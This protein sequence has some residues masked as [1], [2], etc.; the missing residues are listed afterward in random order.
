MLNA[1]RWRKLLR[2]LMRERERLILMLAA[3]T[4]SLAAVGGVMGAFGILEREIS[5]NYLGTLPADITIELSDDV[6]ERALS[7]VRQHAGV[8]DAEARDVLEARVLIGAQWQPILLFVADEPLAVRHNRA[9]LV[10]GAPSG[11]QG[12]LLERTA[13]D[14]LQVRPGQPLAIKTAH[15]PLTT[16]TVSG[17]VH[18]PSLAPAWQER[19]G[20]G[21]LSR[22]ALAALGEPPKLH[23]LRIV[24]A[25]RAETLT[26]LERLA[27]DVAHDL[28]AAGYAV[29][30]IS[31]PPPRQH[32][33]QRQ[34]TTV[35][36]LLMAFSLL[37]LV[38]SG[39][40]VANSLAAI[41]ARQVREIGVMKVLGA[42][43]SQLAAMYAVLILLVA[44]TA[45][46]VAIPLGRG[47]ALTLSTAVAML[48]NF[49]LADT[50]PPSWVVLVQLA[51]GIGV[52]LLLS[53]FPV[54]SA[55]RMSVRDAIGQ[56][57]AASDVLRQRAMRWPRPLRDLLRRPRRLVLTAG[58][59]ATAGAVF[60]TALNLKAS[61]EMNVEKV[62]QTHFYDVDVRFHAPQ[63][64]AEVRK[65]LAAIPSVRR[66]EA[67][68]YAPAAFN[69]G[70]GLPVSHVYPDKSHA[71]LTVLAPPT[72]TQ[73]IRFPVLA[74]RWL[75]SGDVDAVVLTHA[76]LAQRPGT[77]VG[78]KIGLSVDGRE[79]RWKVVGVVEEV[80]S[81]GIVYMTQPGFWSA[82]DE[83]GR[84][85]SFRIAVAAPA[86]KARDEAVSQIERTL[87]AQGYSVA[88]ALP[89]SELRT[90]MSDHIAILIDALL[91]MAATIAVV[92]GLGLGS[93]ASISV[94][95]RTREIGI[96]KTLGALPTR[97]VRMLLAEATWTAALS[98]G[99][100]VLLSLPL[101]WTL[102]VLV[103]RL[104]FVAPL[105]FT[106]RWEAAIVWAGLLL[107]IGA[108]ACW[109]PA[110]RAA[111]IPIVAA[112]TAV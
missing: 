81:A 74:G 24:A 26:G 106:V 87:Y 112:I 72:D 52:P 107:V 9:R 75:R 28:T 59:L 39:I 12:L 47:A 99:A 60:M 80:G 7:I 61:W 111:Q 32:P 13:S 66:I 92:G 84:A 65:V 43:M 44:G 35:L 57:G 6:S 23:E 79:T 22:A 17:L 31:V 94:I 109:V 71:S 62:Y 3:V 36:Y 90:A 56:Y 48:L 98:W 101:T 41:L 11:A 14:L 83:E 15:G 91:A 108:L 1:P 46:L 2:D 20:Y 53:A 38:L 16:L 29:H 103:G 89:L 42:T 100:S 105:P 69:N 8:A 96:Y 77:R 93:A 110:R 50:V 88:V 85:A 70:A 4:V 49:E 21:Y 37:A 73:L 5:R 51:A 55:L 45:V 76:A 104:G 64:I 97:I 68:G 67:W 54:A 58:L 78:D 40:L 33:H 27:K 34:M 95:E 82:M 10:H 25:D 63:P 30:E 86:G 19:M 102:D 18:D